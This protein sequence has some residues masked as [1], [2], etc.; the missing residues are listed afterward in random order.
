M[1]RDTEL[2]I[3]DIKSL[4]NTKGYIYALCMIIFEDFHMALEQLHEINYRERLKTKK[5]L[6]N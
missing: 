6:Q 2:V 4:I 1:M 3:S 5:N